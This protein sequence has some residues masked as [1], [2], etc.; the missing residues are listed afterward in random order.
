MAVAPD[1]F[2]VV[3]IDRGCDVDD[4]LFE[5]VA[6]A[7]WDVGDTL[8]EVAL[9]CCCIADCARKAARKVAKNGRWV[10][11]SADVFMNESEGFR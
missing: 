6:C 7:G 11:I 10:G 3:A 1:G 9:V 4:G 2:D 8:D 5:D